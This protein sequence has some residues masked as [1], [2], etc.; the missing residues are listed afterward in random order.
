[1]AHYFVSYAHPLGFGRCAYVG[2][3]IETIRDVERVEQRLADAH[4]DLHP[5]TVLW[6]TELPGEPPQLNGAIEFI[7]GTPED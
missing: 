1:M 3:P 5:I 2:D 6:W 4:P 7:V